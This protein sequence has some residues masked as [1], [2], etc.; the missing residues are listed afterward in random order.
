MKTFI[1]MTTVALLGLTP[2]AQA[3][4]TESALG[5]TTLTTGQIALIAGGGLLL[6][7]AIAGSGGGGGGSSTTTTTTTTTTSGN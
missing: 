3:Q 1:A 2:A 5:A 4:G 7:G 6:I